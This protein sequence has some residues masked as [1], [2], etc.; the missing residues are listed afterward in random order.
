MIKH[1]D[2]RYCTEINLGHCIYEYAD[3]IDNVSQRFSLIIA[4]AVYNNFAGKP[5]RI[6]VS[7]F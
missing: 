5:T 2:Y 1:K 3:A 7:N 4:Y 6:L